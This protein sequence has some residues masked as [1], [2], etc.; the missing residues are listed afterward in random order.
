MRYTNRLLLLL[1]LL[2]QRIPGDVSMPT[3]VVVCVR[4]DGQLQEVNSERKVVTAGRT[5]T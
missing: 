4:H 5:E 3:N 2:L 1:L